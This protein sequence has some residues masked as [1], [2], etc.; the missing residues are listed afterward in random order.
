VR[1]LV[2]G[3]AGFIGS[4][5]ADRFAA[6]GNHVHVVDNLYS[7]HR[8]N[9][10]PAWGFSELD[11]SEGDDPGGGPGPLRK[12]FG[13]FAPELVVHAAAQVRVRC[14]DHLLD[15]R[16]NVIGSLNVVHLSAV[17]RVRRLVYI[18]TGGA[19]YGEP[20]YLPCDE[21]HPIRPIS[22]YGIS[23]LTVE[24]Y[25]RLYALEHDL[26]YA[27]IRPGNVY[28]PRQDE[29]GEAGVCAIFTGLMR[30][31][32]QP[33]V[34]GSG[35]NTRD[36]VYVGDVV[37]AVWLAATRPE[38]SRRVYNVGTGLETSTLEIFRQLASLT[39]YRGGPRHAPEP[40]EVKR[41][42]LDCNRIKSELGW[43]PELDLREGL[44]RLVGWS[45][46][47]SPR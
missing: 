4:H 34:Y 25:L 1:V 15:A 3:G 19:G 9:L 35:A 42:A 21:D 16:Y 24:H 32:E 10:D 23:K 6:E 26:D 5:I 37:E 8:R 33:V 2:T 13:V 45:A 14:E 41:I 30:A 40:N 46:S 18:S 47:G 17:H 12:L 11:V 29:R 31:G 44:G 22:A 43:K 27:V 28:G 7:G 39:G 20:E 36:Y 38:A